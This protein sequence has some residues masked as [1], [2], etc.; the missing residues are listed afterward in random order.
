VSEQANAATTARLLS[1]WG[2]TAPTRAAVTAPLDEPELRRLVSAAGPRGVVARGLGRSYGDAAQN[3]GGA[4]VELS[5]FDQIQ[6][7]ADTG[8]VRVG[9]GVSID[10]LIRR[11]LPRG[12]FVPV[13]PGT[14]MI[15]IGGAIAADVHG[16]NHH[17]DGTF[18]AHVVE[19]ELLDA[20]G[21]T[22]LLSPTQNSTDFW[23]TVGGM[24]LT[25][26]ITAATVRLLPVT[27]SYMRVDTERATDLDDLMSR[28]ITGDDNYRYTVAWIDCVAGGKSLGRGVL[29]R[30]DHADIDELP[31]T[32]RRD[33]L[34]FDPKVR[35]GIPQMVPGGL[36]NRA[37]IAA[38]NEMWFRKAPK[39][40][41]GDYQRVGTFFHPLDGVRNWNRA[42]G[43]RGFLQYQF[44]VPL[45]EADV[46]RVAIERLR[47]V[48]APSFLA[49]LKRFGA[50]NAAPLS[51]PTPGW[52]LALDVPAGIRDL[53]E[54]LTE[55]D[56]VVAAAGGR[57][58]LAKDS[59]LRSDLL[60]MMYPRLAE[61]RAGRD[62][63][64]PTHRFTSDLARRLA[65]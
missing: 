61:W 60:A 6:L 44:V 55:L 15:S 30:G 17:V 32:K 29:T 37:S 23:L 56:D 22:R 62:L 3:S 5:D 34:A 43:P 58:Y 54:A 4:V 57:I 50:A 45:A 52:T 36:L 26:I 24:G 47:Q 12:W 16:K 39:A 28:M 19:I 11:V 7:D 64:D 18:G 9:A 49:V 21:E 25:G 51:F 42:Y 1:G 33:A 27:S 40:K 31:A 14:R 35:L 46:V 59:R 41:F 48:P 63:L 65:L 53:S 13:T 38:F 8:F 2:R 20:D 10:Q